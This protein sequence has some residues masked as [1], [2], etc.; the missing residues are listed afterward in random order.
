MINKNIEH[1]R[2][3]QLPI[4]GIHATI[5]SILIAIF[6]A[7]SFY[8]HNA[9]QEMELELINTAEKINRIPFLRYAYL[10]PNDFSLPKDAE[11]RGK[12]LTNIVLLLSGNPQDGSYPIE[13]PENQADRAEKAIQLMN[14]IA[15]RYPFPDAL[16][17]T[18]GG[19]NIGP[20]EPIIFGNV[21]D[22][23]NWLLDLNGIL[24]TTRLFR[25]SPNEF[26]SESYLDYFKQL[27]RKK[28]ELI[29]RAK[30]D[31]LLQAQGIIEPKII[32]SNFVEG[33]NKAEEVS[34][35]AEYMLT[36]IDKYRN[37][38]LS[39]NI[40]RIA[41]FLTVFVFFASVIVPIVFKHANRT[42]WICI[43]SIYYLI[44]SVYFLIKSF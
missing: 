27:K 19:W 22:V 11:E 23:S 41:I 34:L 36:K 4:T 18:K 9:I 38:H 10:P 32:F 24:R 2:S 5:L 33:L 17:K 37:S 31:R 40:L 15:H 28:V 21:N 1:Y 7:Y 39:R 6:S 44:I 8:V 43:P 20:R 12:I 35:A 26:L 14:I 25:Y 16:W 30:N 13:I 29:Q 42:F 3:G